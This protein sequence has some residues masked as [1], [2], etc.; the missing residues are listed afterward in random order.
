MKVQ[1][2]QLDLSYLEHWAE[3]LGV[4]DLLKKALEDSGLK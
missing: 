2:T 3:E 4:F 1:S